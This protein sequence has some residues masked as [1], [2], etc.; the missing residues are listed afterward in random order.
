MRL[1]DSTEIRRLANGRVVIV[2][3]TTPVTFV[4]TAEV[5]KC[6]WWMESSNE[7]T[8]ECSAQAVGFDNGFMCT[9]GH[10]HHNDAEY[11]TEDEAEAILRNHGMLAP[12]ARLV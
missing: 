5:F 10:N 12:N 7:G 8:V 11:Y 6:G 9:E 2:N 4:P 3:G 1:T